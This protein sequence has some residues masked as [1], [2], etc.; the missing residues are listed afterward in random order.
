MPYRYDQAQDN[1]TSEGMKEGIAQGCCSVHLFTFV[2]GLTN[3]ETCAALLDFGKRLRLRQHQCLLRPT[4]YYLTL[5]GQLARTNVIRFCYSGCL[6][7]EGSACMLLF[8]SKE[9]FTRKYVQME[10]RHAMQLRKPIIL[11]HE[12][13]ARHGQFDFDPTTGVPVDFQSI[14]FQPGLQLAHARSTV[15]SPS[16]VRSCYADRMA[17]WRS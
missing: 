13:D 14:A 17:L 5:L 10:I 7:I 12:T 3:Y 16:H 9:V 11:V 15:T 8:L 1:L 4:Y 6:G 2:F